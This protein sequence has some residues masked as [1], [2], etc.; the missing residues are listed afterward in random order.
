MT[1]YAR[2]RGRDR[3][4]S[5]SAQ[6]L[7]LASFWCEASDVIRPLVPHFMGACWYTLDPA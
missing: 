4:A 1:S 7:D 5:L 6:G 3:I 2:E